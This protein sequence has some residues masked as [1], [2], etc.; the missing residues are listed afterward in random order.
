[1][2]W[3]T[4]LS[5]LL[6]GAAP[7]YDQIEPVRDSVGHRM[8]QYPPR[9]RA[10][11]LD[12]AGRPVVA[13]VAVSPYM[14]VVARR[15]GGRWRPLYQLARHRAPLMKEWDPLP[16]EAIIALESAYIMEDEEVHDE[17]SV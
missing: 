5:G 8:S 2:K 15:D 6:R 12:T 9:V 3:P 14:E 11:Q 7:R 1:M 16:P 4:R 17:F 10:L 13:A